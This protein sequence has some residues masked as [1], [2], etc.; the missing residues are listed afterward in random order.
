LEK[1]KKI[2]Y[3]FNTIIDLFEKKLIPPRN[4]RQ[5]T[6]YRGCYGGIEFISD[7]RPERKLNFE[8]YG[9]EGT[10]FKNTKFRKTRGPRIEFAET[11]Y[12]VNR[13]SL[14]AEINARNYF[15]ITF[16]PDEDYELKIRAG[17]SS[18]T[19]YICFPYR[20][21]E[22]L[23]FDLRKIFRKIVFLIGPGGVFIGGG[24]GVRGYHPI[25]L[26]KRSKISKILN[27]SII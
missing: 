26:R 24:G 17:Y 8:V 1:Y 9:F 12:T 27:A 22:F 11:L 25:H 6:V 7:G 3:L 16:L 13:R 23:Y 15:A 20:T 14:A 4:W 2:T 18:R 10:S 21:T 5:Y 19:V